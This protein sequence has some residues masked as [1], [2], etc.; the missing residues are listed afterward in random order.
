M[1]T[2]KGLN[3]HYAVVTKFPIFT[4]VKVDVITTRAR[5]KCVIYASSDVWVILIASALWL[6]ERCDVA[7]VLYPG[8]SFAKTGIYTLT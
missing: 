4:R 5:R 1:I 8:S 6:A 2:S 3:V 7:R